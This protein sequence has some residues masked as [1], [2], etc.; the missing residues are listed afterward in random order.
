[1]LPNLGFCF[2]LFITGVLSFPSPF[3]DGTHITVPLIDPSR[4]GTCGAK[5]NY[6][7]TGSIYGRCCSSYDF[8]GNSTAHCFLSH[9]CQSAYGECTNGTPAN[10][11]TPSVDGLCGGSVTCAGSAWDGA[12]CD[13]YGFCTF[14]ATYCLIENG[15]QKGLGQCNQISPDGTCGGTH[16][17]ATYICTGSAFGVC[18]SGDGFCGSDTEHCGLECQG[19]FGPCLAPSPDGSCSWDRGFTCLGSQF[20]E[21]CSGNSWCGN[22]T[23]YCSTKAGCSPGGIGNPY[24]GICMEP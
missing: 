13:S 3:D 23:Q 22:S 11:V 5:A 6:T 12:C 1:M 21:C 16:G 10:Q 17:G 20:G 19:K 9:G 18:C 15:C 2:L 4:D 8:C 7:C 24:L 14:N